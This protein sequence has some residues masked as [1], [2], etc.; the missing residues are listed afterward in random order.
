MSP[1]TLGAGV[2][3][4]ITEEV[5]EFVHLIQLEFASGTVYLS[6]GTVDLDWNGETW[7]AVGGALVI[8]AVEETGDWKAQGVE[9]RLSGVDQTILSAL[10]TSEFRG[11]EARIYR[12]H[13]DSATGDVIT[14]PVLLF[15]GVQLDPYSAEEERG[16]TGNTVSIKTRL[17]GQISVSRSVGVWS[18]TTVHGHYFPGDTFFQHA[19]SLGN[20][21]IYWGSPFPSSVR[22]GGGGSG[23]RLTDDEGNPNEWF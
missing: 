17:S 10:L 18:N 19:S 23:G 11:R 5:G 1:R 14:D 16:R 20:K 12:A 6:T 3:T 22:G 2:A 4:A 9:L 15:Q 13:L 8:G 21:K 7:Q